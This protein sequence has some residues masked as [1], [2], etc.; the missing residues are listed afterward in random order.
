M[1]SQNPGSRYH[2]LLR[3]T[4]TMKHND[5]GKI[6]LILN[7]NVNI[8]CSNSRYKKRFVFPIHSLIMLKPQM[9]TQFVWAP[10]EEICKSFH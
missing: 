10:C 4:M 2:S 1:Y 9:V 5:R 6:M 8:P 3:G 7:L